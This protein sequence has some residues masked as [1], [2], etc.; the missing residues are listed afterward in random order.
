MR[1]S[2]VASLR[3]GFEIGI[4]I[5][6]RGLEKVEQ[7]AADAADGGNFEFTGPYR[8][9]ESPRLQR[10][11]AGHGFVGSVDV[12]R[13]RADAGAMRDVVRMG[14]AIRFTVDNQL[15][16]TLRPALDFLAAMGTG[17]AKAKLAKQR[18]QIPGL[19]FVDGEFDESDAA[20]PRSRLQPGRRR[21]GRTLGRQLI[22]Q[23]DQRTQPVGRGANRRARAEL[24]VEYL[25][26]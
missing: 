15:D 7:T 18:G 24:V 16:I 25:Q 10:F 4:P 6:A 1:R 19:G 5:L 3:Q 21:A 22:L 9:V 17:L 2:L 8:L 14:K 26:R 20:A 13:D 12:D 11:C 23:Q